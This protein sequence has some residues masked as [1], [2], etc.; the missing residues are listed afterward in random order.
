MKGKFISFILFSLSI[1]TSQPSSAQS[2]QQR[3]N[4]SVFTL[5]YKYFNERQAEPI[6]DLAGELFKK[7]LSP[8]TFKHIADQQLFPLGPIRKSSLISF[9][10]NKLSTYKLEFDSGT[11]QLLMTLDKEDKLELFLFKPYKEEAPDKLKP[12]HTSNLMRTL[13][14]K[15]VDSVARN[16]IQK[17]NTVGLSIGIIKNKVIHTYNYGETTE[18]N[19]QMPDA[20]SIYEIGSIT[21]T[22][23]AT[24]LA[25]YAD[26]GKVKLNDP[27]TKY[28][29][30]SVA[31]NKELQGITLEMLSN[32]TSGLPRLPDNFQFHSS[33]PYDPYK[34]YNKQHLFEYLKTCKLNSKPGEVYA[35]SNLAVGLL[36]TILEQVSKKPFEQMVEETICTPLGMQST[37]QHLS[38]VLK[39]RFVTVYNEEGKVTSPWSF[40]TLAP[41]GALRSTVNDLLLYVKANIVK[42]NTKLSKAFELTHQITFNKD[43]K[44]GLGWHT[45]VV[46]GVEYYFHDGGTYGSSSFLAFNIEKDM[47]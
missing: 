25:Y 46:G 37:A 40:N 12:V 17:A 20:N 22:F 14:D 21:K 8:E 30:D 29:P 18:G 1:L 43:A 44:L 41:C 23:T 10:N 28:L 9:Q 36:G 35:Y 34:D 11:L 26:E 2:L 6:Y 24:L 33:D 5:V 4:D 42:N 27:I 32:H 19:G 3:K 13:T 45:I 39:Q 7:Q 15:K 38:P 31:S 47:R 16:Y